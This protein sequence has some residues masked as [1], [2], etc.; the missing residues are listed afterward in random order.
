MKTFTISTL[1]LIAMTASAYAVDFSKPILDLKGAVV[2][3]CPREKPDCGAVLTLAD[4]AQT[5]LQASFQDEQSL[6]ATDK[7]KRFELALRI[8]QTKVD[9]KLSVEELA[10]IKQLVAKAF[11]PLTVGRAYELLDPPK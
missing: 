10:L 11:P 6:P 8:E 5:A 2:V 4:V 7:I 1:A 9:P 3:S